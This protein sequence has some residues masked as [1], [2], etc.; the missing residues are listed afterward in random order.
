MLRPL[1]KISKHVPTHRRE[2]PKDLRLLQN[3]LALPK[4]HWSYFHKKLKQLLSTVPTL[5]VTSARNAPKVALVPCI[6]SWECSSIELSKGLW[7]PPN[8]L[9]LR[10]QPRQKIT[11]FPEINCASPLHDIIYYRASYSV[12]LQIRN[13]PHT[14]NYST[15]PARFAL[16]QRQNFTELVLWNQLVTSIHRTRW[17][18]T[19][20]CATECRWYTT[21][22]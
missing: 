15:E 19:T 13:S 9:Q 5:I 2:A 3:H 16:R 7:S 22:W 1:S 8:S 11:E 12:A 17:D 4:Q 21:E 14:K 20:S 6:D 10:L 18:S